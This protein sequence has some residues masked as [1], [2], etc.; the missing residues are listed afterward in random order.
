MKVVPENILR[1]MDPADRAPMGKAGRTAQE[2]AA[3]CE[4]R[5]ERKLQQEMEWLL[6]LREIYYQRSRM[7][8][9]TT[10]RKG[11]PDFLIILPG[12]RAVAV[13]AKTCTGTLTDDQ[14]RVFQKYEDQT[15]QRVHIVRSLEQFR[16][17]LDFY[18]PPTPRP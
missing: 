2:A 13:E 10:V 16:T 4:Q 12:G 15:G 9:K 17:L 11:T 18:G 1:R 8:K 5:S 7:D 3:K 6:N 14:Y